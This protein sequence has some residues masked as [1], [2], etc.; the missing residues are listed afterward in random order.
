VCVEQANANRNA[1]TLRAGEVHVF[2]T[3]YLRQPM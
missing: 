2:E 1:I 3:R